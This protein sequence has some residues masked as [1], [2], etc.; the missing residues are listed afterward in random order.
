MILI[1]VYKYLHS[2]ESMFS[3]CTPHMQTQ[4]LAGEMLYLELIIETVAF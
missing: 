2:I 1:S 3:S 4:Y